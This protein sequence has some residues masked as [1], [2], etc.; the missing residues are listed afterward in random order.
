MQ[1]VRWK[2]SVQQLKVRYHK[3][4]GSRYKAQ[5]TR[6]NSRIHYPVGEKDSFQLLSSDSWILSIS[7]F[8]RRVCI[9]HQFAGGLCPP[10]RYVFRLIVLSA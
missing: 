4:K 2:R 10:Y 1:K 5:G 3:I 8:K 6:A 9:A 7:L